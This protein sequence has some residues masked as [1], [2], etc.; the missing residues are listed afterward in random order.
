MLDT[1]ADTSTG[2]LRP[3]L[4]DAFW[5][6]VTGDDQWVRAEFDEIINAGWD[7]PPPP[8]PPAPPT[9][10]GQPPCSPR[11]AATHQW[12]VHLGPTREL[13]AAQRSPPIIASHD[14]RSSGC[15]AAELPGTAP[16]AKLA[17][18]PEP[19]LSRCDND[20]LVT[21]SRIP[22]LDEP[23]PLDWDLEDL[24]EPPASRP[25]LFERVIADALP[26]TSLR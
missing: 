21:G 26:G 13:R 3:D 20:A 17:M 23:P 6:I 16:R 15:R 8:S 10:D 9:P 7:T 14:D 5:A 2:I 22:L 11:P 25:V 4:D 24:F 1:A 19:M 18:K 12:T